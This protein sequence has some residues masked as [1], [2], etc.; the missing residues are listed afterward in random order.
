M[1][2]SD[3]IFSTNRDWDPSY[4]RQ[5][6]NDSFDNLSSLWINGV[7]DSVLIDEMEKYESYQPIVEDI[8]LEDEV[9]CTAVQKI[10][11]E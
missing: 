3:D 2:F 7:E 5:L 1:E 4:L 8:S 10:E 11:E 6:F 9:L